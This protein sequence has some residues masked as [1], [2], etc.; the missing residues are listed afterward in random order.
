MALT[1]EIKKAGDI[2]P[3]LTLNLSK[4]AR[5]TVE[6]YWDSPHD[7]D[8]H[9][10]AAINDG[11]GAKVTSLAQVLSTYNC[12]KTNSSGTLDSNADG[13][14]STP[15]GGV[16]HSGDARTGMDTDI[17]EV[18]TIDGSK[19]PQG[20]N[21]IPIFVTIH[22]PKR[23]KFGDVKNAGIRIMNDMGQLIEEYILSK[24][25]AEFD[26]IQ[27]GSLLLGS[28]GWEYV[29]AGQGFNGDFTDILGFFS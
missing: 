3:K 21:E 15:D 19:L 16:T 4:P 12:K 2:T 28:S 20:V 29:P 17:D 18:I 27:M 23:Y 24:Q 22:P 25:F 6:L 10:L 11:N 7:L 13:S 8:A 5:F 9:A 1:L 14:F 26:C